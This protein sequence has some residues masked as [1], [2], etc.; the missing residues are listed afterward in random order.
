MYDAS[1]EYVISKS[2]V[3]LARSGSLGFKAADSRDAVVSRED[4]YDHGDVIPL[5][6]AFYRVIIK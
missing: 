6:Y 5:G 2:S 3:G 1:V 4:F